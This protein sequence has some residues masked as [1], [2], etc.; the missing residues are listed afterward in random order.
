MTQ[1]GKT[2]LHDVFSRVTSNY[3][4]S[5]FKSTTKLNVQCMCHIK[6]WPKNIYNIWWQE[7]RRMQ[8]L[9]GS[10]RGQLAKPADHNGCWLQHG[11]LPSGAPGFDLNLLSR[12]RGQHGRKA[13]YGLSMWSGHLLSFS[14]PPS[15]L[16]HNP[17]LKLPP[18]VILTSPSPSAPYPANANRCPVSKTGIMFLE[19]GL[20]ILCF[21]RLLIITTLSRSG[22]DERQHGGQQVVI[23]CVC[24]LCKTTSPSCLRGDKSLFV[25][26][27]GE[28]GLQFRE[29]R[30]VCKIIIM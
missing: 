24:P 30:D 10:G 6:M 2:G 17:G 16:P 14:S 28:M 15:Q 12:A 19:D 1:E 26:Y 20:V 5:T 21:A 9:D 23:S 11:A 7:I 13:L 25:V 22:G 8:F 3:R 29:W 27:Y 4:Y 18:F